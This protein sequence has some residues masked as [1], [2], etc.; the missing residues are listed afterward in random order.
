MG[1]DD[2]ERDLRDLNRRVGGAHSDRI[3]LTDEHLRLELYRIAHGSLPVEELIAVMLA[4]PDI[5][6]ADAAL[7]EL[8]DHAAAEQSGAAF[9]EWSSAVLDAGVE[10]RAFPSKRIHEWRLLILLDDPS[11]D[12]LADLIAAS[13]W[14]Q[15]SAAERTSERTVLEALAEHGRTKRTRSLAQERLGSL[16]GRST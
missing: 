14:S 15:R 3:L 2:F 11:S 9:G 5:V 8:I 7:V 1:S 6:M 16:G 10:R 4:D 13:D 12:R